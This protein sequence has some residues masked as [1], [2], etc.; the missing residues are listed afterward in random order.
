MSIG[1]PPPVDCVGLFTGA[2]GA[3]GAAGMAGVT[4]SD[5]SVWKEKRFDWAPASNPPSFMLDTFSPD[6]LVFTCKVYLSKYK[7]YI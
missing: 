7:A 6:S 2:T 1:K 4:V 3:I 5:S